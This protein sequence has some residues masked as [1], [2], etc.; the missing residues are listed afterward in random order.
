MILAVTCAFSLNFLEHN[1]YFI[2]FVISVGYSIFF[3]EK[4]KKHGKDVKVIFESLF[5]C[6]CACVDTF[7]CV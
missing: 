4:K 1:N 3:E 6:W 7:L 5:V 2:G